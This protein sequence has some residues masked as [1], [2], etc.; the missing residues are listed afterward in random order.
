MTHIV[1]GWKRLSGTRYKVALFVVKGGRI[2]PTTVVNTFPEFL[3][4]QYS[5]TCR[6]AYEG[7]KSTMKLK[8]PTGEPLT[9]GLGI[10]T[11]GENTK[12]YREINLKI[13][14]TEVTISHM[15]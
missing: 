9:I 12:L 13:N 11:D 2:P 3:S 6:S 8:I 5:R 10:N 14:G 4:S 7:L 15:I 1:P